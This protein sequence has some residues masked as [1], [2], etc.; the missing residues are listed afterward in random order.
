MKSNYR[1]YSGLLCLISAI[2]FAA[3]IVVMRRIHDG[4]G[5][6]SWFPF[7]FI[8]IPIFLGVNMP[9]SYSADYSGFEIKRFG[10]GTRFDYGS[11]E[12]IRTVYTEKPLIF[13]GVELIV[14]G[15]FGQK[16][17]REVTF[18]GVMRDSSGE[19][20]FRRKPRLVQLCEFVKPN[21]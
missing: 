16:T 10:I 7:F 14:T 17:F 20:I 5:Q 15:S 3:F 2:A 21:I 18:R 11:V 13:G 9:C 4:G 19:P 12:D 6:V 8:V 1:G